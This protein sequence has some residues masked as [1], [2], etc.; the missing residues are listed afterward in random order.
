[1]YREKIMQIFTLLIAS[2]IFLIADVGFKTSSNE[3]NVLN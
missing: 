2:N 1:M 3:R